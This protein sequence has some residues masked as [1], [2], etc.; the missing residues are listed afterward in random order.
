MLLPWWGN[1]FLR[2]SCANFMCLQ[3]TRNN[4]YEP[5][6]TCM[7]PLF[8]FLFLFFCCCYI[9]KMYIIFSMVILIKYE[10]MNNDRCDCH[11]QRLVLTWL[12]TFAFSRIRLNPD[13]T[14][15]HYP[16]RSRQC[17]RKEKINHIFFCSSH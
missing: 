2:A 7:L 5:W 13:G 1:I 3:V 4:F 12:P 14:A 15:C 11:F 10:L 9:C 8:F 6:P 16:C 17:R